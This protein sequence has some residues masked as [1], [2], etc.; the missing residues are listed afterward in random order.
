MKVSDLMRGRVLTSRGALCF[1]TPRDPDGS[2]LP[3]V[4]MLHGALRRAE[5]LVSWAPVLMGDFDVLMCDLPGHG[6]DRAEGEPTSDAYA[7][8]LY[9]AIKFFKRP[10]VV[11]GESLGG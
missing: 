8:R 9:E 10:A 6:T 7:N 5:H 4:F 2:N 1:A 11:L 3:M